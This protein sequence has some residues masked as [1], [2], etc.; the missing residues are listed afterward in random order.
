MSRQICKHNHSFSTQS[1]R[2]SFVKFSGIQR[3]CNRNNERSRQTSSR[4]EYIV[5]TSHLNLHPF[6]IPLNS[7]RIQQQ[8]PAQ[9]LHHRVLTRRHQS[10]FPKNSNTPRKTHQAPPKTCEMALTFILPILFCIFLCCLFL[11]RYALLELIRISLGN[12]LDTRTSERI[13]MDGDCLYSTATDLDLE[14]GYGARRREDRR[15]GFMFL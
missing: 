3:C 7:Y 4:L 2:S 8:T 15:K 9:S 5:P 10:P 1:K 12:H 14:K 13:A 6:L 11:N